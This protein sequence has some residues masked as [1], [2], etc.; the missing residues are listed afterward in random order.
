MT[1][2]QEQNVVHRRC[3]PGAF[4]LISSICIAIAI[5]VITALP[6]YLKAREDAMEVDTKSNLHFIQIDIERYW[7][8]HCVYPPDISTL[9]SEGY[10]D[11]MP[12]NVIT[13]EPM[14]DIAFDSYPYQG[15]FTYIPYTFEGNVRAYYLIAYGKNGGTGQDLNEDG[16]DDHAIMIVWNGSCPCQGTPYFPEM[17]PPSLID[18][19][20]MVESD[21][22]STVE[23][24][25]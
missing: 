3:K 12:I 19:L 7:V 25:E 15:D 6:R 23:P 2:N 9:F 14:R 20:N 10:T 11:S 24:E 4:V 5:L 17:A 18:L 16:I 13:H 21:S 1:L 22:Q 8:D